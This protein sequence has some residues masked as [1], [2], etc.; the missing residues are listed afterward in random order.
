MALV[1]EAM[2]YIV[3]AVT[4]GDFASRVSLPKGCTTNWS[5]KSDGENAAGKC[6]VGDGAIEQVEGWLQARGHVGG[7]GLQRHRIRGEREC[8]LRVLRCPGR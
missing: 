3:F 8:R 2:S 4:A 5:F 7:R 6:A 1:S